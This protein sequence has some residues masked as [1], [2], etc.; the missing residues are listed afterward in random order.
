M[1]VA[2]EILSVFLILI[3]LYLVLVHATGFAGDISA[4]ATGG[5][6]LAKTFQGR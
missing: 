4:L 3:A 6:G 1:R 2:R 5:A